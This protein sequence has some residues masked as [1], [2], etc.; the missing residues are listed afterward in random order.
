MKSIINASLKS[1]FKFILVLL[2][3][4]F[5]NKGFSQI[6][7]PVKWKASVEKISESEYN[8][9][10][11]AMIETGWH[12]YS[13]NV[14]QGGPIPTTFFFTEN[15]GFK[16]I[17]KVTEEKGHT[18]MDETFNMKVK[19][20]SNKASFR[21][22]VQVQKGTQ[23]VEGSVEFMVCR[24]TQCLPPT[25]IDLSFDLTKAKAVKKKKTVTAKKVY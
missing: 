1:S 15:K 4:T 17:G 10:A 3:I 13:Q 9:V 22:K 14:K 2:F 20:F 16:L 12:I 8:L 5:S 18:V 25:E 6:Y 24:E 21:Q 11:T 7:E 19:S 23:K